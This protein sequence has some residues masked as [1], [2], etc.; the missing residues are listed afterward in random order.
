MRF[1]IIISLLATFALVSCSGGSTPDPGNVP[2]PIVTPDPTV[3]TGTV[4]ITGAPLVS[5]DDTGLIGDQDASKW[6]LKLI[7]PVESVDSAV[8]PVAN[9][10][11]NS[12]AVTASGE[13]LL[14][15]N[16][17]PAVDL[18]GGME[19]ATAVTINIPITVVV[20]ETTQVFASLEVFAPSGAS[21]VHTTSQL[22]GGRLRVRYAVETPGMRDTGFVELD[23]LGNR[24]RRD[25]NG[26]D[27]FDDEEYFADS[28]RDC[29]SD[30]LRDQMRD[31]MHDPRRFNIEGVMAEFDRQHHRIMVGDAWYRVTDRTEVWQQARLVHLSNLEAGQLLRIKGYVGQMG[32]NYAEEIRV[33]NR[34]D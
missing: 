21:S 24:I 33:V 3:I 12:E 34:T 2:D 28:D 15:V 6:S 5:L 23:W 22:G 20:G 16:L 10:T 9:S 7:D 13:Y 19:A 27:D 1:K 30:E 17:Q 31:P 8:I 4:E 25:T 26:D 14:S 29:I 11:F 32:L 18:S